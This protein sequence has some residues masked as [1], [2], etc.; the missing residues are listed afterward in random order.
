MDIADIKAALNKPTLSESSKK[1][2]ASII[3]NLMSNMG[4]TN[5]KDL[6]KS[7]KV[8]TYLKPK[9]ANHRKTTLSAVITFLSC[10]GYETHNAVKKYRSLVKKDNLIVDD[11][12]KEQAKSDDEIING[13]SW[14]KINSIYD[15]MTKRYKNF[16]KNG[17]DLTMKD[18][19]GIQD[20]IIATIYIKQKPRRLMDYTELKIKDV[21][22]DTDNYINRGNFVFNKYKTQKKYSTQKVKIE[23]DVKKIL[24]KWIKIIPDNISYLLFDNNSNKLNSVK[25]NQRLKKIFGFSANMIR[26]AFLT[27]MYKDAPSLK[28]AEDTA[29]DM[30]HSVATAIKHYVKLD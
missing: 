27:D 23:P 20:Y 21:D 10:L 30:G 7:R 5:P 11:K 12:E 6:L 26:S 22:K 15:G 17:D 8:L 14:D 18:L 1:T 28:N 19:Q 13:K 24:N 16:D 29:T 4:I 9:T 25:L 2:Y 3:K